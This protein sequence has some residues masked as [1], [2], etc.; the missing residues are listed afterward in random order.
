MRI[1]QRGVIGYFFVKDCVFKIT[2]ITNA[3]EMFVYVFFHGK[4]KRMNNADTKKPGLLLQPGWL[5]S[6]LILISVQHPFHQRSPSF[7]LPWV[8]F[9]SIHT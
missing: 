3:G 9:P 4:E 1:H 6:E 7:F 8:I 2:A 5:L